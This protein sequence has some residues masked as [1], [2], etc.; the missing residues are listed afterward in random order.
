MVRCFTGLL[1]SKALTDGVFK[2]QGMLSILPTVVSM[3]STPF[4]W[5]NTPLPDNLSVPGYEFAVGRERI[6]HRALWA[7]EPTCAL[8]TYLQPGFLDIVC[9]C[10]ISTLSAIR[11][12]SVFHIKNAVR[13]LRFRHP[14]VASRLAWPNVAHPG[15]YPDPYSARLVYEAVGDAE[16]EKWVDEVVIDRTAVLD[17]G[18]GTL[19]SAVDIVL[20]EVGQESSSPHTTLFNVYLV[21]GSGSDAALVIRGAHALFDAIGLLKCMD[22]LVAEISRSLGAENSISQTLSWGDEVSR[23]VGSA[24]DYMKVPWSP[25]EDIQDGVRLQNVKRILEEIKVRIRV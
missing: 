19:Q 9:S 13:A 1:I 12:L 15:P 7:M 16:V 6:W 14:A 22:R 21:A 8:C 11:P 23:L 4:S 25:E 24:V 10:Q 20:R 3:T 17:Q 18:D 2:G 5:K